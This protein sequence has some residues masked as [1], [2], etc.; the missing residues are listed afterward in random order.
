[1]YIFFLAAAALALAAVLWYHQV[2]GTAEDIPPLEESTDQR[3]HRVIAEDPYL[4]DALIEAVQALE[5]VMAHPELGGPGFL[6][7]QFPAAPEAGGAVITA[8]YPNIREGLYRRVVR[9]ELDDLAAAGMPEALLSLKPSFETESGGVVLLT[10]R[11]GEL[12]PEFAESLRGHRERGIA[13]AVLAEVLKAKLPQF[14][15]RTFG[16]GLLLSQDHERSRAD[17]G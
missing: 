13:L 12:P 14:S 7:I 11:A 9:Q 15:I 4:A 5:S 6:L 16:S 2:S 17:A 1:M 8:Q 3:L 10:V